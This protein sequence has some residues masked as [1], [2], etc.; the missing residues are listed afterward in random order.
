MG[1]R[2]RFYPEQPTKRRIIRGSILG[3]KIIAAPLIV[4]AAIV[5]GA[6]AVA[7]GIVALPTYGSYKLIKQIQ[8]NFLIILIIFFYYLP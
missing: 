5:I 1:C 8:V 7:V 2:Y 4:S 6:G 3:C